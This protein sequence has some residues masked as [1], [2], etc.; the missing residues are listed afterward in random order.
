MKHLIY[1][2]FHEYVSPSPDTLAAIF[3][4]SNGAMKIFSAVKDEKIN[5]FRWIRLGFWSK[6][7][8]FLLHENNIIPVMRQ[9]NIIRYFMGI[10]IQ[11]LILL[12]L[13]YLSTF[14]K[15]ANITNIILF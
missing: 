9:K 15:N 13:I 1:E 3:V 11:I 8:S 7:I 10:F 12:N 14:C 6:V 4:E 5:V 2:D